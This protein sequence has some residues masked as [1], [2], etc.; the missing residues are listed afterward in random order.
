M[1]DTGTQVVLGTF[2]ATFIYC[3]LVLRVVRGVSD[4]YMREQVRRF[5]PSLEGGG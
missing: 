4:R 3:L 5:A 1:R 2:I